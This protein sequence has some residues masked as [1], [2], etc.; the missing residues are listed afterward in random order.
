MAAKKPSFA[1]RLTA[2]RAEMAHAGVAGFMIT[3]TDPWQG[4]FIAAHFNRLEWLTGFNGSAGTAV[5]LRD[6]AAIFSDPRYL[7]RLKNE[8]DTTLYKIVD[9]TQTTVADWLDHNLPGGEM[10]Y[11]PWLHTPGE[12]KK[13]TGRKFSILPLAVNPVDVL[14][15]D[16]PP[17]PL[18]PAEIFPIKYAGKIAQEKIE[19]IVVDIKRQGAC[20]AVITQL[21]SIAWLLNIRGT[22][23]P[24]IPVA[25]SYV[26][27]RTDG[28]VT[29]IIHPDKV[30]SEVRETLPP[31]VHI[32]SIDNIRH[33]I[34]SLAQAADGPVM[35]DPARSPV[36]FQ[37]CLSE[38]GAAILEK[39]DP[40]TAPKAIKNEHEQNAMRAAHVRDGLALTRLFKWLEQHNRVEEL[41]ELQVQA[42]ADAYRRMAAEYRSDSFPVIFGYGPNGAV[43]H[44]VSS[45][46]TDQKL[47]QGNLLLADSGAQYIDGTTDVTRTVAI[48]DV[49]DE[50]RHRFTLVLKGHIAVASA[51]FPAG[52]T[53]AQID[54]LA[55]APLWAHGLD[56][57]HGTGHG[58]GC[59]LWVHEE[60][61]SISK[62]GNDPIEP[63][64]IISNEPGYYKEGEYGIRIESL[65]LA[66]KL[67]VCPDTGKDLIGF[68]TITLCP[69]D[70]RLIVVDMLTT[71]ERDWLNAYHAR[72]RDTLSP[73]LSGAEREWLTAA[74]VPI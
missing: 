4:E 41:T 62:R 25:L 40:C 13:F 47:K 33:V 71:L 22:D 18:A 53:G 16:R 5:V 11:D 20:A 32:V 38:G 23:T 8:I 24:E 31:S 19:Q 56:Y 46:Q 28:N 43:I 50:M 29:W 55:R 3:R 61:A 42:K 6:R 36:W 65:V 15:N 17:Y 44:Y 39:K 52:T 64:M 63:G 1:D 26:V 45:S 59:Y 66:Q 70:Q 48:G 68:E 60:S 74:T 34:I 30:S 51:K 73:L 37:Q 10:G 14:W 69:I 27:I 57:A 7:L 2:L 49:A 9:I 21:D 54:P 67:G 72:V 58:V 35:L 12:I